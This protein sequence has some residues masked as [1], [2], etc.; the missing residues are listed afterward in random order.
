M[1]VC[2]KRAIP[3]FWN[4]SL[5]KKNSFLYE[6]SREIKNETEAISRGNK[7]DRVV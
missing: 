3:V 4:L 5:R 2:V 1:G 7:N 6:N